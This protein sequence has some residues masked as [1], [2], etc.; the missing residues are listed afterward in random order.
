MAERNQVQITDID[1]PFISMVIFMIKW[2]IAS[3]PAIFILTIAGGI[4]TAIFGGL[5]GM[6]GG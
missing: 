4:I 1:M 5:F 2:A 3:I 6:F